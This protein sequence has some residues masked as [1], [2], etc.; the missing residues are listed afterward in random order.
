MNAER[1]VQLLKEKEKTLTAAE[2]LTCGMFQSVIGGVS[3]VSNIF[4][5]GFVTYSAQMKQWIGVPEEIVQNF[6]T[7]SAECAEAMAVSAK[8]AAQTDYAISF[9]GVAGPDMLEG[10]P[11]GTV[12][13]GIASPH[14]V[15][16]YLLNSQY[17]NRQEIRQEAVE[18]GLKQLIEVVSHNEE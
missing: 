18:Y 5:G 11:V 14:E 6:G 2:S 10:K 7:V 8:R 3:G 4:P 17:Q 13:I 1:L 12:W 9:T 16:C 15:Y